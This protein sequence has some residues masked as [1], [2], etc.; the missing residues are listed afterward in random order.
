[1]DEQALAPSIDRV[2]EPAMPVL[3]WQLEAGWRAIASTAMGGGIAEAAWVINAQVPE[4]Y[5][6]TDVEAHLRELAAE[7]GCAGAGVGFLTAAAVEHVVTHAD[8][9]VV[10]HATVGLRQPT[11]AAAPDGEESDAVGTVN[12]VAFVP[13]ALTDA[14]LVNAVMT[15][16]EA[17]AQAL[18]ELGI[19]GT[20]TA[21]DAVCVLSRCDGASEPFAGPR[22]RVGA[23]LSPRA[24]RRARRRGSND[25]T[26]LDDRA[27]DRR[28]SLR[29]VG[30]RRADRGRRR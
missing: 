5:E 2:G 17:K 24:S 20:G 15:V 13:H 22:S 12:I 30:A 11:G 8:S 18:T 10:V 26:A 4:D 14:A 23:P 3:V 28:H 27:G 1:V 16:T 7:A 9:D 21:S 6:R 29:E 25:R 19:A